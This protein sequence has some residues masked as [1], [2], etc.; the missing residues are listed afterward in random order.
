VLPAGQFK[1]EA[2][3]LVV[4]GSAPLAQ[5]KPVTQPALFVTCWPPH[6][7]QFAMGGQEL[8][9]APPVPVRPPIPPAP[10]PTP[11]V[12]AGQQSR[13]VPQV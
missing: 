3:G 9:P 12:P 10:P 2:H 5:R 11:P 1:V 13:S 7:L 8:P 4:Q 6:Q